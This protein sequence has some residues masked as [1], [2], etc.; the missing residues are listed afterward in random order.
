[1]ASSV[2]DERGPRSNVPSVGSSA[3]R[4]DPTHARSRFA[5]DE[6]QE[7]VPRQS[8][9]PSQRDANHAWGMSIDLNACIGCNAC[10]IACQAE[11]SIP[12][13]GKE[14][15]NCI[16]IARRCAICTLATRM[17]LGQSMALPVET[18][19]LYWHFVDGVWILLYPLL[20]LV[21]RHG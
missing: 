5:S 10:T 17:R 16:T 12:V 11:N 1:M 20:Y 14:P 8:L 9:Y 6:D 21:G 3:T 13:V 2:Q 4:P 19:G 18:V 15:H 7:R